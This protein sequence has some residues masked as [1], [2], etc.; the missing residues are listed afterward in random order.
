MAP[1]EDFAWSADLERDTFSMANVEPQLPGL[2]RQGWERIEEIVRAEACR[3]GS[4]VVFTGPVFPGSV[5]IGKDYVVV[6]EGF[7]KIAVDPK[8]VGHW[9]LWRS[10]KILQ[11]ET[12]KR[13]QSR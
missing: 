2:N 10:K 5:K 7:F 8:R 9:P 3:H 13:P 4:I 1:A 6:S 12:L 11:R